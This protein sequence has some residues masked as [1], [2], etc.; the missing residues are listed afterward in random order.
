MRNLAGLLETHLVLMGLGLSIQPGV[1][2]GGVGEPH[3]RGDGL[4]LLGFIGQVKTGTDS[5][6]CSAIRL[7]FSLYERAEGI[8]GFIQFRREE[9][10]DRSARLIFIAISG[11]SRD[12]SFYQVILHEFYGS[13][14]YRTTLPLAI[15]YIK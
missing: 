9:H 10:G 3:L 6:S 7:H 12:P 11:E 8:R 15:P 5:F 4:I 13:I 1:G 14:N 2:N